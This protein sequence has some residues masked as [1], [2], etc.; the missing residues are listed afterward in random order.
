M[1]GAT[2]NASAE[3]RRQRNGEASTSATR[4]SFWCVE[5]KQIPRFVPAGRPPS[6]LASTVTTKPL[7]QKKSI[8]LLPSQSGHLH[9][10][11]TRRDESAERFSRARRG[12]ENVRWPGSRSVSAERASHAYPVGRSHGSTRTQAR[13]ATVLGPPHAER[14]RHRWCQRSGQS[15]SSSGIRLS[16]IPP[17]LTFPQVRP[18]PGG[19][20]GIPDSLDT[21]QGSTSG[22]AALSHVRRV[23]YLS[24]PA[25]FSHLPLRPHIYFVFIFFL[26][27]SSGLMAGAPRSHNQFLL[28][29]PAQTLLFELLWRN[30]KKSRNPPKKVPETIAGRGLSSY[31]CCVTGKTGNHRQAPTGPIHIRRN[32]QPSPFTIGDRYVLRRH[33]H[34]RQRHRRRRGC[35]RQPAAHHEELD[36][37]RD[38]RNRDHRPALGGR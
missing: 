38:T 33:H 29:R 7:P 22:P 37:V 14:D 35:G 10:D 11:A 13:T 32:G 31:V 36:H 2:S 9:E 15:V 4:E 5:G 16:W 3:S 24:S 26:W 1:T 34:E 30:P 17:C 19:S 12:R 18:R 6:M 23:S 25:W 27:L 21:K 8:S 28:L 20:T